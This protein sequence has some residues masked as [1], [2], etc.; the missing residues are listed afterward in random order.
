MTRTAKSN[1]DRA[2]L[3]ALP[4]VDIGDRQLRPAD[5]GVRDLPAQSTAVRAHGAGER[6][7]SIPDAGRHRPLLVLGCHDLLRSHGRAQ[8]EALRGVRPAR[9]RAGRRSEGDG[10]EP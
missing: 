2:E 10:T 8:L 7:L 3:P 5:A 9:A 4:V 6:A 1:E